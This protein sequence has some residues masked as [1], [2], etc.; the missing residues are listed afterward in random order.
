MIV[1]IVIL[2]VVS[3]VTNSSFLKVLNYLNLNLYH[4]AD[5]MCII[6]FVYNKIFCLTCLIILI[7]KIV[8]VLVLKN[9]NVVV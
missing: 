3:D 5:Q 6:L 2:F 7:L 8:L 1:I 4:Y 9:L